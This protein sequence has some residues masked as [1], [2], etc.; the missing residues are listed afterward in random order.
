MFSLQ[1]KKKNE[2]LKSELSNLSKQNSL[3]V[4][5]TSKRGSL[6]S[7][8]SS[9][10]EVSSGRASFKSSAQSV[11]MMMGRKVMEVIFIANTT[12]HET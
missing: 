4:S 2:E 10:G 3:S 12:P 1:V 11:Q 5:A 9:E 6:F 7:P 8:E